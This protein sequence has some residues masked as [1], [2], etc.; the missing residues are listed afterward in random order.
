[1]FRTLALLPATSACDS[2]AFLYQLLTYV[3]ILVGIAL[4]IKLLVPYLGGMLG[5]PWGQ[6]FNIVGWIIIALMA[7]KLLF[8]LFACVL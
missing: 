7:L 3:V 2:P 8:M 4:I 6:I 1:M 5:G